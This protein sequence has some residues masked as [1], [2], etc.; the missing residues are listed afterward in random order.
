G[1]VVGPGVEEGVGGGVRRLAGGAEE[2]GGG[3]EQ[4]EAVR[5]GGELGEQGGA[6]DLGRQ[7]AQ[8]AFVGQVG[9]GGVVEDAGGVDDG[10]DRAGVAA[11][12]VQGKGEGGA[13][14][15]VGPG[16]V[17]GDAVVPQSGD[18]GRGVRVGG[19]AAQQGEAAGAAAD[20]LFGD[21]PAEAAQSA[22]D[23]VDPVRGDAGAA[24][25]GAGAGQAGHQASGVAQGHEAFVVGVRERGPQGVGA[26][27]LRQVDQGGRQFRV[28][29][30]EGEAEAPGEGLL[31]V[32]D[33]GAV[34]GRLAAAH[35][36]EEARGRAASGQGPDQVEGGQAAQ[37]RRLLG[38]AVVGDGGGVQGGELDDAGGRGVGERLVQ[39]PGQL[40]G[41]GGVEDVA[42][43]ALGGE[44]GSAPGDDVRYRRVQPAGEPGGRAGGVGEDQP[45]PPVGPA[46]RVGA[47]V[48][49]GFEPGAVQRGQRGEPE[50]LGLQD[51]VLVGVPQP[52]VAGEGVAGEG[53][54]VAGHPGRGG[55]PAGEPQPAGPGG[56]EGPV[57]GR[58]VGQGRGVEGGVEERRVDQVALGGPAG[59]AGE[60]GPVGAVALGEAAEG[61]PVVDAEGGE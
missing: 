5:F 1:Q 3:G 37:P 8:D 42:A 49:A 15:D 48:P 25:V 39:Q 27:R 14:G 31:R 10:G 52:Q 56:Y 4:H 22:G 59:Q 7:D 43:G 19:A 53:P 11:Q 18:P 54:R 50:V 12:G 9:H 24:V 29:L 46:G 34:T 35:D 41:V 55:A 26:V 28:L 6:E 45:A 13:V 57:R 36:D 20:Q 30:V 21:D 33:P 58:A 38:G 44:P 23:E 51:E 2:S 40:V 17:H 47:G 16:E 61:G 32:G 60:R